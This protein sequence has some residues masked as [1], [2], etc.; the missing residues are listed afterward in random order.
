[1]NTY[2]KG[3]NSIIENQTKQIYWSQPFKI[4]FISDIL[5]PWFYLIIVGSQKAREP[6]LWGLEIA[7]TIGDIFLIICIQRLLS[8]E[9]GR[10]EMATRLQLARISCAIFFTFPLLNSYVLEDERVLFIILLICNIVDLFVCLY[11]LI[12]N[13]KK[14]SIIKANISN[15]YLKLDKE[16]ISGISFSNIELADNGSYFEIKYED[17]R[18]I[19]EQNSMLCNLYID[20]IGGTY[21][22][23]VENSTEAINIIINEIKAKTSNEIEPFFDIT[24]SKSKI[25][26]NNLTPEEQLK[27]YITSELEKKEKSDDLLSVY[28]KYKKYVYGYYPKEETK[29]ALYDLIIK[30]K[31]TDYEGNSELMITVLENKLKSFNK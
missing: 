23:S 7:Y 20:H 14:M 18:N 17:I 1:M 9:H 24:K 11:T 21:K 13:I 10:Y 22:L 3:N 6:F 29:E 25:N 4:S 28:W 31:N 19:R 2:F 27:N 15:C 26:A 16:S 12:N 5:L 30:C 8:D